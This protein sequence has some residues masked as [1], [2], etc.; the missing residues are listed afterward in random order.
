MVAPVMIVPIMWALLTRP[1][2]LPVRTALAIVAADRMVP[3]L[4]CN[5]RL[6]WWAGSSTAKLFPPS[7]ENSFVVMVLA[8]LSC[9]VP[10]P[11]L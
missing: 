2:L 11:S 4:S 3:P 1:R 8:N 7:P 5:P 6:E 9:V 10:E